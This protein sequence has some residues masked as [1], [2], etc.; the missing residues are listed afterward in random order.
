[1][2]EWKS[3]MVG[4]KQVTGYELQVTSLT[5]YDLRL[6]VYGRNKHWGKMNIGMTE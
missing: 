4:E 3:G 5:P 2:E 6:T 1:M